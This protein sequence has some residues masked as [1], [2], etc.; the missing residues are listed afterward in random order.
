MAIRGINLEIGSASVARLWG[1][2]FGSTFGEPLGDTTIR[3]RNASEVDRALLVDLTCGDLDRDADNTFV[4]IFV[5]EKLKSL[6]AYRNIPLLCGNNESDRECLTF[7]ATL[8]AETVVAALATLVF[9][10]LR[11]FANF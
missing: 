2:A 8:L 11:R 7:F 4:G 9:T 5:L 1:R 3:L 10:W 6:L